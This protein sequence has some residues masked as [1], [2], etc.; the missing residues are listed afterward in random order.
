MAL[1]PNGYWFI[2]LFYCMLGK[3]I[4]FFCSVRSNHSLGCFCRKTFSPGAFHFDPNFLS[5]ILRPFQLTFSCPHL[6]PLGL[7][8]CP[9]MCFALNDTFITLFS[10]E[11]WEILVLL[12]GIN[13]SRFLL[14]TSDMSYLKMNFIA[15]YLGG[16]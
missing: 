1:S 3:R 9:I 5:A 16:F 10:L 7:W 4:S 6:L 8:W 2:L 15:W 14:L 13:T 12:M 11:H